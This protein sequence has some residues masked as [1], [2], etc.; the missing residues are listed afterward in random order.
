MP[1]KKKITPVESKL[2]E[3]FNGAEFNKAV[4]QLIEAIRQYYVKIEGITPDTNKLVETAVKI[5]EKRND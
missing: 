5:V 2:P 1:S 4:D 3:Y